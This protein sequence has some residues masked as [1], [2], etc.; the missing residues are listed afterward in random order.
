M[1]HAMEDV[2]HSEKP[3]GAAIAEER[4]AQGQISIL[5]SLFIRR[6][7]TFISFTSVYISD[8]FEKGFHLL[9][10]KFLSEKI[11]VRLTFA[12]LFFRDPCKLWKKGYKQ[13]SRGGNVRAPGVLAGRDKAT[14]A[15]S[16]A[17]LSYPW[18]SITVSILPALQMTI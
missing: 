11:K 6:E 7:F 18:H 1:Q 16:G 15:L 12:L 9:I 3:P 14:V 10:S 17:L 5:S 2:R 4:R 8:I 13:N